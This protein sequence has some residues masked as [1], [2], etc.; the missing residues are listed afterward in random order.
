MKLKADLKADAVLVLT[1]IIWGSTFPLSKDILE[2]WP[3]V[4][5]LVMRMGVS[6]VL[7]ALLFRRQLARAGRA[8]WRAGATLGLLLSVGMTGLI[9][10]QV[11]TTA[12]R[13]AFI[14]GLTTPLVPFVA[15]LLTRARPGLENLLGVVLA[16]AGG[17][18]ILAP[19][20]EGGAG[21]AN[22]GDFLTLGCTVFFAAHLTLMSV[23]ARRHDVRALTVIQT[24][25]ISAVLI[26][27]WLALLAGGALGGTEGLPLA[28]AREF[29]PLAWTG[30]VLWRVAYMVVVATVLNF[31]LWTWAQGRMSATH[32]AII[33]SLE[34]VFA[35][36]FAVWM[37]GAQEWTGGRANFGAALILAGIIV[38]ELHWGGRRAAREA[39]EVRGG[40]GD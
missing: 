15:Y 19:Q 40:A 34:P 8:E 23:Y 5:Y 14:A 26:V 9:V 21:A 10:G 32:A 22:A 27:Y 6:A 29:Q 13:S 20:G 38:S 7:M 35:T 36:L 1:T 16:S 12:A 18:L 31:L 39:G 33:F 25:T 17:M 24:V 30:G 3:P 28:V 4:A 2:H 37:R 11:Y